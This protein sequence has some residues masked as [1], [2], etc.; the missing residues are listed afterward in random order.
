M[1]QT[2]ITP[3]KSLLGKINSYQG[4]KNDVQ[5]WEILL[6]LARFENDNF[7]TTVKL[8][9]EITWRLRIPID[10]LSTGT[11]LVNYW[12]RIYIPRDANGNLLFQSV[13][14]K[15]VGIS[16]KPIPSSDLT[17]DVLYS[18]DSGANFTSVFNNP[19]FCILPSGNQTITYGTNTVGTLKDK[20][21][22]SI[23]CSSSGE[24]TGLEV[25]LEGYY[26]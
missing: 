19:T 15:T 22:I 26:E 9:S 4:K 23:D 24:V 6:D 11:D 16:A 10:S 17:I 21:L 18:R 2:P 12:P 20:D 5:L 13:R 14:L 1:S 8:Q 25:F 7:N 3:R